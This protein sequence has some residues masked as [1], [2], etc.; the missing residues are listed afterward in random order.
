MVSD[1]ILFT[2]EQSEKAYID[3]TATLAEG[4]GLKTIFT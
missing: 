4:F 1:V 2:S 3:I